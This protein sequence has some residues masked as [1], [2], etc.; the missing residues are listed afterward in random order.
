M[1]ELIEGKPVRESVS[2]CSEIALPNDANPLGHLL[3]GRVMH[4]VDLAGAIA[5]TR[6]SRLAVV[7]AAIDYM[8]FLHPI[9][10]GQ[11]ITLRSSV[12]RVFRTSM[13]VGVKVFVEDLGTGEVRHTSSAYLT[14]VA[15]DAAGQ[16]IPVRPVI[17][18]TAEEI[19]RYE[20]AG[21][22]RQHRLEQRE[23]SRV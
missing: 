16:R 19:R 23:R 7:T 5:A 13:E 21:R 20:E 6:H 17:P 14:F 8:T 10:I 11:L 18:E 1:D 2:E 12:N 4:L 15:I 3:G 9:H 22:R